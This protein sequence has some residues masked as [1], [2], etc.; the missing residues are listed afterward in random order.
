MV[1]LIVLIECLGW[2]K[3]SAREK[4]SENVRK[5]YFITKNKELHTVITYFSEE[6]NYL[7]HTD[8][9]EGG[10]FHGCHRVLERL[11]VAINRSSRKN[12]C[13]VD[14]FGLVG[15]LKK[16]SQVFCTPRCHVT[17]NWEVGISQEYTVAYLVGSKYLTSFDFRV[18]Q[19][20][21]VIQ[22]FLHALEIQEQSGPRFD[23]YVSFCRINSGRI[24]R[25]CLLD[26]G[27]SLNKPLV[28]LLVRMCRQ[29]YAYL[30]SLESTISST[31]L[32]ED[33]NR[34]REIYFRDYHLNQELKAESEH[35]CI[36]QLLGRLHGIVKGRTKEMGLKN[37]AYYLLGKRS[38]QVN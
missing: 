29:L 20:M 22:L 25:R 11:A 24:Y 38:V 16:E 28:A 7:T 13:S 17:R 21:E 6:M 12:S 2:R 34:V 10:R 9:V 8:P 27:D 33:M 15:L 5:I 18:L 14:L 19:T 23:F 35:R 31:Q 30:Y 36:L 3:Q 32:I 37:R 26:H 4:I 1:N